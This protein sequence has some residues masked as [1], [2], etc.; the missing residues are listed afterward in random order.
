MLKHFQKI[1]F[2]PFFS[3]VCTPS[4]SSS[5]VPSF[6]LGSPRC[7]SLNLS[8]VQT[9]TSNRCGLIVHIC[10]RVSGSR[11]HSHGLMGRGDVVR[12]CVFHAYHLHTGQCL[13][14]APVLCCSHI[15]PLIS[16]KPE[17]AFSVC[18]AV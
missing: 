18:L 15:V 3:S 9:K 6:L 1:H 16:L 5:V 11:G 8:A 2:F 13:T 7:L 10:L 4:F 17:L 12:L 14:E